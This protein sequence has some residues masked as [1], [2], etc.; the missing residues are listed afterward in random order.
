MSVGE[1]GD[2]AGGASVGFGVAGAA[3]VRVEIFCSEARSEGAGEGAGEG[4]GQGKVQGK[5]KARGR[6]K[7]KG[8]GKVQGKGAEEG[9]VGTRSDHAVDCSEEA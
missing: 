5:G 1:E 8:K 6:C 7:G 9:L 3:G 2:G 4:E